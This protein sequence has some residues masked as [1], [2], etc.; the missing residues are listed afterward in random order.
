MGQ[1]H[2][3]DIGTMRPRFGRVTQVLSV[4]FVLAGI[5]AGLAG[6]NSGHQTSPG[7]DDNGLILL[8]LG[9]AYLVVGVGLWMEYLWAWRAGLALTSIVVAVDVVRGTYDGGLVAWSVFLVLFAVSLAQGVRDRRTLT[10][11]NPPLGNDA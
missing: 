2:P 6:L 5:G 1:G 11:G 8:A 7:T 3:V 9:A 4:V 10:P